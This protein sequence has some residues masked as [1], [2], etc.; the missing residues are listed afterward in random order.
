MT[1]SDDPIEKL[2]ERPILFSGPMVRA[3]L[4]G[5]KTQTRRVVKPQPEHGA[6]P[7]HWSPTGWAARSGHGDGNC[8]CQPIRC[9][10][11]EPGDR[12]WVRE[13]WRP[14]IAHHCTVGACDCADVRVRY[15]ADGAERFFADETIPI[16]WTMPKS[17][18]R[19]MVPSVF[20]P[21][22]ACRL[23]LDLL[24]VR[25][26]RLHDI[27]DADIISEGVTRE[28]VAAMIGCHPGSIP[29]LHDAWRLGWTHINGA[30]SWAS[31]PWVWVLGLGAPEV[32]KR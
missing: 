7:C 12:L 2:R 32:N 24:S 19:G 16:E 14:Q 18:A 15:A 28:I 27:S 25:V 3:I 30:A 5:T 23:T 11:G 9:P 29:T 1:T 4:D 26:E 6:G 21:R 31:N 13:T 17:A 20:L 8:T 10:Y 22:W